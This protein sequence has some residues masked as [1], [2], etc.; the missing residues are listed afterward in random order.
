MAKKGHD[1]A[2]NMLDTPVHEFLQPKG[3]GYAL[4]IGVNKYQSARHVLGAIND[5][6]AIRQTLLLENGWKSQNIR[7]LLDAQATR[8]RVSKALYWLV[9][10]RD[11]DD[12]LFLHFSGHG[13]WTLTPDGWECCI[14]CTEYQQYGPA[15]MG[16]IT[17]SELCQALS[18][19]EAGAKLLMI[20]DC[21]FSGGLLK[22]PRRHLP[23]GLP[24]EV[25]ELLKVGPT[26]K[27]KQ[28]P[29]KRFLILKE[30]G[31]RLEFA[32]KRPTSGYA[33]PL[34]EV[35]EIKGDPLMQL[36]YFDVMYPI[37]ERGTKSRRRF[38]L[39]PPDPWMIAIAYVMLEG[40]VQGFA[41]DAVK[42]T[43]TATLSKLRKCGLAPTKRKS[44]KT[45]P[46]NS[47]KGF[48]WE[49][50][51][52][53]GEKI[54]ELFVGIQKAVRQTKRKEVKGIV[55]KKTTSKSKKT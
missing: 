41:W 23:A 45:P 24:A 27:S 52:T 1:S 10:G 48:V 4:L 2:A 53:D 35:S 37:V 32:D 8:A 15:A 12:S 34:D 51:G 5:V 28:A 49:E 14:C 9:S 46:S 55:K 44:R 42:G 50:Y 29:K 54:Y 31:R 40:I 19:K 33:I 16:V 13:S 6:A 11:A 30:N 18:E 38:K 3:R 7:V 39:S 47:R 22:G 17:G 25:R 43:V 26:N 36:L 21:C 20:A